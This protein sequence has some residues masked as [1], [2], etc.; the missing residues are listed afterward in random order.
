MEFAETP[1]FTKLIVEYLSDDEY[2]MLQNMLV[3]DPQMGDIIP[4]SR[5]LRKIR[6]YSSGRGKRG[7][8]RVIYYWYQAGE[9]VLLILPYQKTSKSDLTHRE[10]KLLRNIVEEY[11]P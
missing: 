7:G 4:G 11:F 1:L 6:W 10:I 2:R 8:L 5:G 3:M 9:V